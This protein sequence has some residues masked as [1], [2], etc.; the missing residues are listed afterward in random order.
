[1][2][3][4]RA[5]GFV[6]VSLR[7]ND[8]EGRAAVKLGLILQHASV[9]FDNSRSDRQPETGPAVLGGKE[10]VKQPLLDFG[11]DAFA[12][13]GDLEDHD[14]SMRAAQ[15]FR[16]RSGAQRDGSIVTNTVGGV[17]HQVDQDL[18]D[19]LLIDANA[20]RQGLVQ[21][22]PDLLFLQLWSEQ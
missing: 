6:M 8:T 7:Q 4:I 10:W 17:L 5:I 19:L 1:M 3:R 15:M 16:F 11:R 18:F 13:V 14:F 9:L 20:R 22:Q 21:D 12:R 2:R